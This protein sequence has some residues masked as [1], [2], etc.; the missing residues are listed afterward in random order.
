MF[1]STLLAEMNE[2]QQERYEHYR[3][4]RLHRPAVK[5]VRGRAPLSSLHSHALSGCLI[6]DR[7]DNEDCL[8][9]GFFQ[10]KCSNRC[11]RGE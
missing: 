7:L 11:R 10:R 5:K 4:S 6:S 9:E 3:R 1:N 2:E 8:G